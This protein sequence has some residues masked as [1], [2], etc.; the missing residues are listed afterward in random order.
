VFR[1]FTTPTCI[2]LLTLVDPGSFVFTLITSN[3][4]K[5]TCSTAGV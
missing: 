4:P 2:I 3:L 1:I 5:S